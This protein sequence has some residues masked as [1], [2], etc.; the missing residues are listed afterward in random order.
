V[1]DAEVLKALMVAGSKMTWRR[2]LLLHDPCSD[3]GHNPPFLPLS[4]SP[5][6]VQLPSR[7]RSNKPINE[8]HGEE[9][10]EQG[11]EEEMQQER[12]RGIIMLN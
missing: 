1:S 11:D 8:M 7:E 4:P 2:D 12:G 5:T 9:E 10:E 6:T 3:T